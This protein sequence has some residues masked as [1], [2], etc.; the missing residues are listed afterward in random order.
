VRTLLLVPIVHTPAEMGFAQQAVREIKAQLYGL[1]RVKRYEAEVSRFWN[2]LEARLSDQTINRVYND[3]LPLGGEAGREFV[4]RIAAAGSRNYRLLA[5][6][7]AKGAQLEATEDA[8]LLREE[9][10]YLQRLVGALSLAEKTELASTYKRRLQTL[11][12]E[13]DRY[14]AGQINTSLRHGERGLIF[15]G[16]SHDIRSYLDEDIAIVLL[17]R[18]KQ[19]AAVPGDH[20]TTITGRDDTVEQARRSNADAGQG[21][22]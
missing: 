18:G 14:I 7:V 19:S 20:Q 16:E 5:R 3:S 21:N 17:V 12:Q 15:L 2:E 4:A 10:D 1:Q 11:M 9:V 22:S 6:L 8:S 13:R